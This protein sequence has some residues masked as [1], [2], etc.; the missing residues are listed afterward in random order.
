MMIWLLNKCFT[1]SKHHERKIRKTSTTMMIKAM[2][3]R[4]TWQFPSMLVA[5]TLLSLCCINLLP[6]TYADPTTGQTK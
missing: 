1:K 6:A 3:L 4:T 5:D 2:R